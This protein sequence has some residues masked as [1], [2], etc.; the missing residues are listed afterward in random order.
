MILGFGYKWI[1][2]QVRGLAPERVTL[3]TLRA[4]RNLDRYVNNGLFA[5]LEQP[6]DK[7][8]L[9]RYP[10]AQR[11]TLYRQATDALRGVCPLGL[12][13]ETPQVWDALGLDKDAKSCNCGS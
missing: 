5:A 10:L 2:E 11:L 13:E 7:V 4:E 9:A 1:I 8:G 3:G 12:C 6:A